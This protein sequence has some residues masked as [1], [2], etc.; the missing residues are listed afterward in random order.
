MADV[1]AAF[2]WTLAR[3]HSWGSPIPAAGLVRL[4]A[5]TA[6]HDELRTTLETEV[7]ELSFV[8]QSP[9][10]I[11]IPNGQDAHREAADWLHE[12]TELD[13]LVIAATLS[14][15]PEEWPEDG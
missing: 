6:D 13:E 10:G 1:A 9:D 2:V 4:V 12:R 7:L 5:D 8:A 3:R 11:F 15:L 14:R